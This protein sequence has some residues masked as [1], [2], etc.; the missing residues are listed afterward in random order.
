MYNSSRQSTELQEKAI[1]DVLLSAVGFKKGTIKQR[2]FIARCQGKLTDSST[3]ADSQVQWR[4]FLE[5]LIEYVEDWPAVMTDQD[6]M[7][8]K[9]DTVH[10][11]DGLQGIKNKLVKEVTRQRELQQELQ[12]VGTVIDTL[13][14]QRSE[15]EEQLSSRPGALKVDNLVNQIEDTH[16]AT[17]DALEQMKLRRKRDTLEL[18]KLVGQDC[19]GWS[20]E[21]N[22]ELIKV[23]TV[24]YLLCYIAHVVAEGVKSRQYC[25]MRCTVG[26]KGVCLWCRPPM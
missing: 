23:C 21:G 6:Y 5:S 9:A 16:K 1:P 10:L 22:P 8:E 20:V 12:R 17:S 14:Q 15:R 13:T 2:D 3:P 19:K 4:A 26:A 24:C 7:R 18:Q 11:T 25:L